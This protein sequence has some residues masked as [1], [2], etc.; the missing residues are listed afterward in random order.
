MVVIA[1]GSLCVKYGMGKSGA[2]VARSARTS[3]LRKATHEQRK[4]RT[5]LV[6]ADN[7]SETL[8]RPDTAMR[9]R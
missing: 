1:Y 4:S 2:P 5:G 6:R 3:S 9:V 8:P 7:E